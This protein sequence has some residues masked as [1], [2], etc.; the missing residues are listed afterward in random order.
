[1][2]YRRFGHLDFEVSALV[3]R[4]PRRVKAGGVTDAM[5]QYVDVVPTL[6]EAAG[7]EAAGVDTGCPDAK[8]KRGFDGRSFLGVLLGK[9]RAHRNLVYGAHTTRGIIAGSD[10]YPVRSVRSVRAMASPP[11]TPLGRA[12]AAL[13]QCIWWMPLAA[14]GRYPTTAP[15]P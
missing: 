6:I 1:M 13:P 5:V 12:T 7:G 4:W 15:S 3:I 10:C 8:G 14:A 11:R 2:Q 9:K